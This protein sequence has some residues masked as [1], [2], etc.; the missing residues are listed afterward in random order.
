MKRKYS[1][2]DLRLFDESFLEG[3]I[4]TTL[5]GDD[6]YKFSMG[7]YIYDYTEYR[8]AEMTWRFK[9]RTKSVAL[10]DFVSEED[11]M[12]EYSYVKNLQANKTEQHYLRGT[13][14]YE[15]RMF[16]EGYLE[17]LGSL[18][19]PDVK[20]GI[21]ND[22]QL[23]IETTGKWINSMHTEVPILKIVN[24]L[25]YRTILK[26][27]SRMKRE[28]IYAEGIRRLYETL[29]SIKEHPNTFFADFS[30][31]RTPNPLWHAFVVERAVDELGKQ[32]KGTSKVS[33]ASDNGVTPVGTRAHEL[34]MGI[35]AL[36]FDG[37]ERSIRESVLLLNNQWWKKYGHGLSIDLPDT[38]GTEYIMSILPE[39]MLRDWKGQRIDS[40]DPMQAI[41]Y[42]MD[43][44]NKQGIDPRKKMLIPSDGL[45]LNDMFTV[46]DAFADK[47][48]L[49]FGWGT[50]FSNNLGLPLLSIVMKPHSIELKN[51]T[52][53]QKPFSTGKK[54]CVKLSDNIEKAM[55]EPS[56]VAAYKKALGYHETYAKECEV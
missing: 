44:Y 41:P 24:G 22:R 36:L 54:F 47:V 46:A 52:L 53:A 6:F 14:E 26:G 42:I 49:S 45:K 27:M 29:E 5:L 55:G 23:L 48:D 11:F 30:N 9:N 7:N 2:I 13:N 28:S 34:Q 4:N 31:R 10:A 19:I 35:T 18:N 56:T 25:Y 17:T 39:T 8:E 20:F 15:T 21:D 50:R 1:N 51:E 3:Q 43:Q 32:F 12:K 38:Y 37:S 33:L 16:S 40:K